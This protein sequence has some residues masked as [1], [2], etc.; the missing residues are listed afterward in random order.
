MTV[1]LCTCG[2]SAAKNLPREPRFDAAWVESQGGVTAGA[3]SLLD[4]FWQYPMEDEQ[5]LTRHLSA[6]IHSLARMGLSPGDRVV[7]F[8]SETLDGQACAE[9][10]KLYLERQRPGIDCAVRVVEGLQ[11]RDA[12]RFRSRGVVN[13]VKSVL[14]EIESHGAPQCVFNP[15]GGFKSLVP[16]A[17]LVG[18]IKGVESRYIFEQSSELMVLPPL[19]VQFARERLEPIQALIERIERESYIARG[20]WE[21]AIPYEERQAYIALF[22]HEGQEVTLSPVGWL[23]LEALRQPRALVPFLSLKAIDDLTK[24]RAIEGCKPVAFLSRVAKDRQQLES[25]KHDSFSN[26]LFWLKP[27]NHTRYLSSV[28]G[29][30]LLVWRIVD[31]DDYDELLQSNRANDQGQRIVN[32]RRSRYEPFFRLDLYETERT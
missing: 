7:L 27:G 3:K 11:V 13:F 24:V 29:W 9:A 18:M 28:E 32:E 10:V 2:T 20:E 19:P 22:E 4:G 16:Y 1:Y 14:H 21:S 15:T 12:A 30:R 31:H 26:G 25:A 8:S 6:E 17:V 23:I 5:A